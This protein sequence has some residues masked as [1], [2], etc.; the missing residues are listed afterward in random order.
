M[1]LTLLYIRPYLEHLTGC[2]N[3]YFLLKQSVGRSCPHINRDK[4]HNSENLESVLKARNQKSS[5]PEGSFLEVRAR[6]APLSSNLGIFECLKSISQQSACSACNIC[7]LGTASIAA[8]RAF[9]CLNKNNQFQAHFCTQ[10]E[11]CIPLFSATR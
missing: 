11:I 6:R 3:L 2:T 4:V 1:K 9:S 8:A 10:I 5:T 7:K